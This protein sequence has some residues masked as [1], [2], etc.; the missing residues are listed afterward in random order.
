MK[1][2]DKP[3]AYWTRWFCLPIVL[4]TALVVF[5]LFVVY[6]T[7]I[8]VFHL[9][10]Q[11]GVGFVAALGWMFLAF[12]IMPDHKIKGSFACLIFGTVLSWILIGK[13]FWPDYS[14]MTRLS[15]YITWAGGILGLAAIILLQGRK[16]RKPNQQLNRIEN[17]AQ[18]SN[19]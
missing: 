8:P 16:K 2:Q 9:W 15:V 14:G 12:V 5:L 6:A 3:V 7:S 1:I 11:S 4:M 18:F 13:T 10:W 19:G 17:C